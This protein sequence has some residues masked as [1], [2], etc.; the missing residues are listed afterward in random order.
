MER[1]KVLTFIDW[2]NCETSIDR[3]KRNKWGPWFYDYKN[4]TLNVSKEY[5]GHLFH[6][7]IDLSRCNNSAEL[8][9]WIFQISGKTWADADVIYY[10]ISALDDIIGIVRFW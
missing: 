1:I 5:E 2:Q 9:D 8:L 4:H 10:L 7:D 6:Y 3:I